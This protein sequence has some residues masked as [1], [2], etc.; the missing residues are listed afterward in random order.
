MQLKSYKIVQNYFL[1]TKNRAK[2]FKKKSWE[3]KPRKDKIK[4]WEKIREK[5]QG[6]IRGKNQ[7]KWKKIMRKKIDKKY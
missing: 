6:K 5:N 4:N 3:E 2:I 1:G 7:K